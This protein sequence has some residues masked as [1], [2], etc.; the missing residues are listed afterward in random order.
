MGRYKQ[1]Q[2]KT[3]VDEECSKFIDQRKKAK[4]NWF[5]DPSQITADNPNHIR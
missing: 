1:E 5:Q 4:F 3:W 2:H